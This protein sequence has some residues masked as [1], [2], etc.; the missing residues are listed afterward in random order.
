MITN[1]IKKTKAIFSYLSLIYIGIFVSV[2]AFITYLD[3][4]FSKPEV[5]PT[6]VEVPSIKFLSSEEVASEK[7]KL[8][9]LSNTPTLVK[10]EVTKD[11][12]S[13]VMTDEQIK[14]ATTENSNTEL[15]K[16]YLISDGTTQKE[17][18]SDTKDYVYV[19]Q[20]SGIS[21][22]TTQTDTNLES[23]IT[24]FILEGRI[25]SKTDREIVITTS[26][27][28]GFGKI[29][30]SPSTNIL[31]NEKNITL[32]D[33]KVSDTVKAEGTGSFESKTMTAKVITMTGV[34]Q[35]IPTN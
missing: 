22:T 5:K 3:I 18:T 11:T 9:P 28:S 26:D 16:T 24:S 32:A 35:I 19:R 34:T 7:Q 4:K 25:Y 8:I 10:E 31:I 17:E 15:P 12:F 27:N 23:K 20:N 13:E 2:I 6:P 1:P 33:L 21:V 30:I 29:I 14:S